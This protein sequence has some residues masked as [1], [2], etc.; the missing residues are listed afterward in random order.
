M[1]IIPNKIIPF[2]GFYAINLFGIIFI[3]DSKETIDEIRYTPLFQALLVHEETHTTQ[4]NRYLLKWFTFYLLYLYYY[5]ILLF[6][7][8]FNNEKAYRNIP[9][10]IEAYE[11]EKQ[12]LMYNIK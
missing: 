2:K 12:Y 10:E 6:K 1:K 7:Y 11:R 8:N 3:R 4:A 5:I 9:Y